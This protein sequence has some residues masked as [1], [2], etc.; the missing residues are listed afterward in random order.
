MNYYDV[1]F[2]VSLQLCVM[3]S[4]SCCWVLRRLLKSSP[5]WNR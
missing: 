1:T 3:I 2:Y 4:Q 5:T